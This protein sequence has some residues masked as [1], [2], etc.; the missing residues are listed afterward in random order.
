MVAAGEPF[1]STTCVEE[2]KSKSPVSSSAGGYWSRTCLQRNPGATSQH[3]ARLCQWSMSQSGT[4]T[5]KLFYINCID[6][7]GNTCAHFWVY[8]ADEM[9]ANII[10]TEHGDTTEL[11]NLDT[12]AIQVELYTIEQTCVFLNAEKINYSFLNL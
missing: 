8:A 4:L 12:D 5:S 7:A 9:D 6:S 2:N 1:L 10:A 3:T 11:F